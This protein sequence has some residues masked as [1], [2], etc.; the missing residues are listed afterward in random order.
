[1]KG[2]KAFYYDMSCM[3]TLGHIFQYEVGKEY[4][5]PKTEQLAMCKSGFHFCKELAC[6]YN[7]YPDSIWTRV[8]EIEALGKV[9]TECEG[10]KCCTDY[11]RIVRE[12]EPS[13]IVDNLQH[14]HG[15]GLWAILS[16]YHNC[17]VQ[18]C[19]M[20]E[21]CE[22]LLLEDR[23]N[24]IKTFRKALERAVVSEE[25]TSMFGTAEASHVYGSVET[26]DGRLVHGE[27]DN[28]EEK[29]E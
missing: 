27:N 20:P 3:P 12:L 1:M 25:F 16:L 26:V 5:L 15:L 7:W 11:I 9:L 2:Y 21:N 23:V 18:P 19:G 29:K 13:E 17:L 24:R 4:T 8:C 6:V 14:G 10:T 22:T 28:K